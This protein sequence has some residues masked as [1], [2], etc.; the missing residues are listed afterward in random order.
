MTVCMKSCPKN[1]YCVLVKVGE[2]GESK[3]F[4]VE[5]TWGELYPDEVPAI[6]LDAFFNKHL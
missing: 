1:K 4:L 2:A 6:S 5:I 3:S